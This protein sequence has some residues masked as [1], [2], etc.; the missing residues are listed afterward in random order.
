M[1]RRALG[2]PTRP[3]NFEQLPAIGRVTISSPAVM[4]PL[5][6]LNREKRY[7]DQIKPFNFLLT[8]HVK[9]FGH[10]IGG[11]PERFHLIA[12]YESDPRRW[13]ETDWIDQFTGNRYSTT[14]SGHHGTR[15]TARVK[16]Y[17]DVLREYEFHPESKCADVDGN[18][19]GKQT[20]GLLQRRHVRIEQIKNIGKESNSLEHVK[21]GTIH[22]AQSVYT[23]YPDPQRDE[24]T[25]KLVPVL[26][27]LP[28][29]ILER[30]S[31]LSRRMLND[32]LAGRSRPHRKNRELLAS[33]VRKLG[34]I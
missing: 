34:L 4:R 33:I 15:Q 1:N 29:P 31:G 8:C 22:S 7:S 13:L 12:P 3:L 9:P 17:G 19:S 26:G 25:T 20:I 16:T 23:G 5:T 6:E 24:W 14:T 21:S 18:P 30:E 2:L 28:P 10:P 27:T 11:D 32:T